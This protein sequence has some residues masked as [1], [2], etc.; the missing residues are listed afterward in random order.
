MAPSVVIVV[1][2]LA[3]VALVGVLLAGVFGARKKRDR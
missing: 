1:I 2:L 3:G